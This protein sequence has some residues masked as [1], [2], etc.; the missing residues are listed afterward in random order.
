MDSPNSG[1]LLC[2]EEVIDPSLSNSIIGNDIF[3]VSG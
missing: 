2:L 3:L 1:L